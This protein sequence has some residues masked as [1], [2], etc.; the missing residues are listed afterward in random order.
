MSPFAETELEVQ[1]L[2]I[3]GGVAEEYRLDVCQRTNPYV[4]LP[5]TR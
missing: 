4:V 5:N 3:G 1:P 2:R